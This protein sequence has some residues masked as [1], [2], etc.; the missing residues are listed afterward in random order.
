ME[1]VFTLGY[2]GKAE[3]DQTRV[4]YA[5]AERR[6][7]SNINQIKTLQSERAKMTLYEF[8]TQQL[9]LQGDVETSQREVEQ[10]I[11]DGIS[12]AAEALAIKEE[13]EQTS[14]KAVSYTHLRAHE[15]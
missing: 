2:R 9:T 4:T 11:N 7:T 6:V 3:R 13:A 12:K 14:Q 8:K 1:E 15:T 5:D 10:S